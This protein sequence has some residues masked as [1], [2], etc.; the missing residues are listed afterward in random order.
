[1]VNL[2]AGRWSCETSGS[3]EPAS[4]PCVHHLRKSVGQEDTSVPISSIR[5]SSSLVERCS[6]RAPC[7]RPTLCTVHCECGA[8]QILLHVCTD[9]VGSYLVL[10]LF[11]VFVAGRDSRS[12]QALAAHKGGGVGVAVVLVVLAGCVDSIE[13]AGQQS[14]FDFQPPEPQNDFGE[15][16]RCHA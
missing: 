6:Q 3:G 7:H 13:P 11:V 2:Q 4:G 1:M 9:Q 5:V 12:R 16:R 14:R 10:Q 8:R 15:H